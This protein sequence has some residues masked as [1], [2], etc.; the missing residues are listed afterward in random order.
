MLLLA[1]EGASGQ[2]AT[3]LLQ[4][5][6]TDETKAVLPGVTITAQN[7]DT[8]LTR[9]TV[10][11]AQGRYLLTALQPGRYSLVAELA[12]FAVVRR[13]GLT[14][15]IG[16]EATVPI[17]MQLVT[18]Q[19]TVTVT[20]ESPL[21]EVSKT[22]LGSTITAQKLDQL[23]L[24]G[25]DYSNLITLAAG[26]TPDGGA[27]G[28]ASFGRNSGR[29]GYRVD[30]VSQENNLT[31]GSRGSLSP[32][33]VQEFQVL[34]NLFNAEYGT[35][36]GPIVNIL[37]RSGTNN[38]QGRLAIFARADELDARPYFATGD[39]PF[40]Q[41]WYSGS[42]GGPILQNRIHYFGAVEGL[43][44]DETAVVTSQLLP[45]EYPKSTRGVKFLSRLDAQFGPNNHATYR[46]NI[47]DSST[48]NNGVGGLD[49]IERGRKSTP[50]RQDHQA[51]LTSVMSNTWL[52]ELRVQYA[53]LNS[54]SRE[55]NCAGCPAISRPSGN[56]GKATN[57]P[58]YY[59]ETR[60]QIVNTTSW[61]KGAHN[62]KMGVDYNR[63]WTDIFFP[64]TADGSFT[65]ETDRPF[66]PA[67]GSTYPV[68]YDVIVGDP[69]EQVPDEL[70]AL[71]V[72]DSWRVTS[73]LTINAG[74][75]YDWQG[76]YGV[77]HDRN[78]FG[79][80]FGFSWD[81]K[82]D[83]NFLIRGG[84]GLFYDRN[85][86][87]LA[88]FAI[89][90]ASNLTRIRILNPGYPDPYGPNPNGTRGGSPPQ[91]GRTV[92]ADNKRI[93]YS[94]RASLGVV[95]ALTPYMR[96]TSDFV[97]TRGL[98]VLR[99]RDINP[100]VDDAT[101]RRLDPT[102]GPIT[103]QEASGKTFYYGW[104]SELEHQFHRNLQAT[105]AYVLSWSRNDLENPISQLDFREAMARA[106]NRQVI[107][108]SAMYQLPMGFQVGG[109]VRA[110]SGD[111]YS[112]LLG[113][114]LNRDGF[115][116]ERPEG[117]ARMAHE[118][119]WNWVVDARVSKYF[120]IAGSRRLELIAEAFNLTN[121]PNFGIPENRLTSAN[122]GT[123][124]AMDT[125][126]NP[127]QV[128]L[129]ARFSF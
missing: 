102:Q 46:Y 8:G 30:G 37:T 59:D 128:Q 19:E 38:V 44:Q 66:D 87:E 76:Q 71:F 67:D 43:R 105:F 50:R 116:T 129:G 92:I 21:V 80:R 51:T 41:Q 2:V 85:R 57:M 18:V 89:Q 81:P 108:G 115:N 11:D 101:G 124:V 86:G 13:T 122:F 7:D 125:A 123:F 94:E 117:E 112:V 23:P 34:T 88:L 40:S 35:A 4:G 9:T 72:Q 20:G 33:S 114:D 79:P 82:G 127:R 15:T 26:V 70:V 121:R 28:M 120:T 107:S 12:G 83:G 36:S 53:P 84:S 27:A 29:V 109:L 17:Q 119:P 65:F 56:L 110:R 106:G 55:Q 52:N 77:S 47:D 93:T 78:N 75:R 10:T 74:L 99:N 31:V 64:N 58:Q 96:L 100:V 48:T 69:F 5:D 60:L 16:Q 61:T 1:A 68:Q 54:G 25:R 39:A 95:K 97:W 3:A 14:L 103:Q 118:G 6:V 91:V 63:L 32:D 45:G 42:I 62:V 49:T 104:E 24:Q 98:K 90:S 111:Y 22:T 113:R 126:Y 73:R